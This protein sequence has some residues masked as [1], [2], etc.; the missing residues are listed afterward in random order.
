MFFEL[1]ILILGSYCTFPS[2]GKL[3][4][5]IQSQLVVYLFQYYLEKPMFKMYVNVFD[6]QYVMTDSSFV[7]M[8][9]I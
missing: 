7:Q 6:C 1:E 5:I 3:Q 8:L 9:C 2:P 4:W